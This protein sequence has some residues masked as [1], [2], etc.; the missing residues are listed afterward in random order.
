MKKK[1][2]YFSLFFVLILLV[3]LFIDSKNYNNILSTLDDH[4][5]T[6]I[7]LEH[8]EETV[9]IAFSDPNFNQIIELTSEL[10]LGFRYIGLPLIGQPITITFYS[11]DKELFTVGPGVKYTIINEKRFYTSWGSFNKAEELD[12]IIS[13]YY[14]YRP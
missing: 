7:T 14:G 12:K 8:Y 3:V 1:I 6:R 5:I 10:D 4:N 13:S 2:F 11:G 9:D